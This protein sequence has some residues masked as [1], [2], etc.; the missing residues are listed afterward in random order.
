MLHTVLGARGFVGSR[1]VARLQAEGREVYAPAR[2][3]AAIFERPLGAVF[4]C[5]GM[6]ADYERDPAATVEAHAGL[7][8]RLIAQGRFSRILYLSSTRLYDSL[9]VGP[10]QTQAP[11]V[12]D[13][14]NPRS[15]YDLTKGL[16]ENLALACSQG[17]G[18]V[19][20]LSGVF[21]W[22]DGAPG[23]LSQ[24]LQRSARDRMFT[25]DSAPGLTRDYIHLDDCVRALVAIMD[26]QACDIFNV[27]SGE[28]VSNGE[29]AEVFNARGWRIAFTRSGGES[30]LP[31]CDVAPLAALG[32]QPRRTREI[33]ERWIEGRIA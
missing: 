24:I 4:Y 32:F 17:R 29:I 21:D 27:A 18:A 19:A 20:R 31:V 16:G 1:L 10:A 11:L 30:P 14:R 13:P 6:T 15:L 9:G 12:V 28:N 8:S 5:V 26:S 2:G 23:F 3:D 25:L 33:I 22:N 7:L